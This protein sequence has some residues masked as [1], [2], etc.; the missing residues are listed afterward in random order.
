MVVLE[1]L[2]VS[3]DLHSCCY[4]HV[5]SLLHVHL[6]DQTCSIEFGNK[7]CLL[8]SD[9]VCRICMAK[10]ACPGNMRESAAVMWL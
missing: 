4:L 7:L 2:F 3:W 1:N 8:L 9:S 6:F 10:L 5:L